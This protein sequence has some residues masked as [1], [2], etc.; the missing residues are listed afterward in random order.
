[1]LNVPRATTRATLIKDDLAIESRV[2][3]PE[4]TGSAAEYFR[5]WIVNLFFS[6]ATLGIYS[7]WAKVRKKK[8]FYGSTRLDGDTFDY[9]A[10]PKAILKGRIV[11]FVVF[12]AYAFASQLYP[13][14]AVAFIVIGLLLL[15]WLAVRSLAFN[16]RRSSWRGLPFDFSATTKDAAKVFLGVGILIPLTVGLAFPYFVARLKSFVVS[17]HAYGATGIECQ[18]PARPVYG[19]YLRAFLILLGTGILS[20]I[21]VAV[22]TPALGPAKQV[23]W[24][25]LLFVL[26][27]YAGYAIAYAYIQAQ[28]TNLVWNAARARGVRFESNLRALN[29]LKLYFTNLLAIACSAGL[30]V[31]WAVVRTLRYRLEQFAVVVERE[32]VYVAA[33]EPNGV[34]ATGQELGDI[35]NMDFGV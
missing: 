16:A 4:F 32:V 15:P 7:A 25:A 24:S 33:A 19:I 20:S 8:Y 11:A 26:V 17:N 28:T 9:V 34:G 2:L 14:S 10:D 29:L 18:V 30:L 6:L 5:I 3:R 1:L 27:T 12:V 22:L 31:P 35:F 13:P 23:R 21:L